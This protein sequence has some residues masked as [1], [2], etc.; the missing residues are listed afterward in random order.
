MTQ[1][2]VIGGGFAGLSAAVALAARGLRPTLLEA[3]PHLGGRAYSFTDAATGQQVDNGQHAMMG[4]YAHALSFLDRIGA[5]GKIARQ[6]N[7]RVAMTHPIHGEGVIAAAPLPGPLHMLGGV[8]G[9]RLLAAR[10]RWQALLGGLRILHM[11]RRRDARL[12][13]STVAELLNQVGQSANAQAAFWNPLAIATLN[14]TPA[15]AAAAPFAA[16]LARAFFGTRRDSQFVLPRVGLSD[17]YTGDA[18][19]FIESRG[20]RIEL[21]AAVDGL[22]VHDGRIAAV[23]LRDG[24]R[25]AADAVVAAVPPR[26]LCSFLPEGLRLNPPFRALEAFAGSPI[27]S[28]HLWLDRPVLAHVFLGMIGT[29]TQWIFNRTRLWRGAPGEKASRRRHPVEGGAPSPRTVEGGAPSPPGEWGGVRGQCLSAA[30]SAGRALVS[31]ENAQIAATVMDELRAVVP[32]ARAAAVLRSVVV[33]EK[34]ATI[35]N[36]PAVERMR[37][38]PQTPIANLLLAGDWT[39]TGLPPTIESAV[40]SG[41]RAAALLVERARGGPL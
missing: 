27:V 39:A 5:G 25:V 38:P 23:S 29:T 11:H 33:K 32:A 17:L 34:D 9:Y 7:L 1:V 15:R 22:A 40:A 31:H 30:I 26:A 10:E 28:V 41:D 21:H 18:R 4:C 8:L 12:A 13:A 37:P 16:V 6:T 19:R 35:S 36:T 3:R 14:E 20:G 2:I 24:R